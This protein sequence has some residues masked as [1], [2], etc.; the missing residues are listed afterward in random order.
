MPKFERAGSGEGEW[1]EPSRRRAG[2]GKTPYK[3]WKATRDLI[4]LRISQDPVLKLSPRE[5]SDTLGIPLST[6]R[7]ALNSAKEAGRRFKASRPAPADD[8]K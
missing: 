8:E 4:L 7:D 3:Q 2:R 5:L 6:L 1:V